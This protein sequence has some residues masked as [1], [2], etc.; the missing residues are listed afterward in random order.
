M[1][2][3]KRPSRPDDPAF[4]CD[5]S[6]DCGT[7]YEGVSVREY[8]AAQALAGLMVGRSV[9]GSPD[10]A[11]QVAD[12]AVA[13]ADALLSRLATTPPPAEKDR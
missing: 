7:Y 1:I 9:D 5:V 4:P 11:R 8:F 3:G 12:R 6:D 13:V 10:E 2:S